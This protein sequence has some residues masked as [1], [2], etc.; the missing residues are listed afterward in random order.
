[1][2]IVL[3]EVAISANRHSLVC[4]NT[5][6]FFDAELTVRRGVSTPCASLFSINSKLSTRTM[7]N[8]A[9]GAAS[10]AENSIVCDSSMIWVAM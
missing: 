4:S 5:A 7:S 10:G 6:V 8:G 3:V 9:L 1:M 2:R